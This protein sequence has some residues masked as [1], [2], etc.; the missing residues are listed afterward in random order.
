M[1][2][3]LKELHHFHSGSFHVKNLLVP[4][5][6][7]IC[8]GEFTAKWWDKNHSKVISHFFTIEPHH[9]HCLTIPFRVDLARPVRIWF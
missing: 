3:N 8:G 6:S 1:D 5:R 9:S 7:N 2:V 4:L